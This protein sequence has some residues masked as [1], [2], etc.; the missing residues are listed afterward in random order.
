MAYL[1]DGGSVGQ[2]APFKPEFKEAA[3]P[4][5]DILAIWRVGQAVVKGNPFNKKLGQQFQMIG[6]VCKDIILE[7]AITARWEQPPEWQPLAGTF[8]GA[9]ELLVAASAQDVALLGVSS[10]GCKF[11]AV[12]GIRRGLMGGYAALQRR[13]LEMAGNPDG[14]SSQFDTL[15][16]HIGALYVPLGQIVVPEALQNLGLQ[17]A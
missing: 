3:H 6:D 4:V 12:P 14:E 7:T 17:Q 16:P 1:D 8:P 11:S 9:S 5:G 15:I 2:E 10:A 13:T